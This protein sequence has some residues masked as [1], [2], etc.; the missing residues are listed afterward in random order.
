MKAEEA[1]A[2]KQVGWQKTGT[3]KG[4][5]S[6]GFL[7]L[8]FFSTVFPKYLGY[9]GFVFLVTFS[10]FGG[11]FFFAPV[12][13][14]KSNPGKHMLAQP[15]TRRHGKRGWTRRSC[16][17]GEIHLLCQAMN[18]ATRIMQELSHFDEEVGE[19]NAR[20][21]KKLEG[22]VAGVSSSSA[23]QSYTRTT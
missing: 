6:L 4:D 19:V 21:Q 2:V 3:G 11:P 13:A 12:R 23:C 5:F 17:L 22:F 14:P 10:I 1:F 7:G 16:P 8:P 9:F 15:E 20:C 18:S